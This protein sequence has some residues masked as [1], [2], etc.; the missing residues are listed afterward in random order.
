MGEVN[1]QVIQVM[2]CKEKEQ[3]GARYIEGSIPRQLRDCAYMEP[4]VVIN[5]V[6]FEQ[7]MTIIENA[8]RAAEENL[9]KRTGAKTTNFPELEKAGIRFVGEREE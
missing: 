6:Y 1:N 5:Q 8:Y 4:V 3:N 7:M 2:Y 9:V